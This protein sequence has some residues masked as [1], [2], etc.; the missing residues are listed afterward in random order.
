MCAVL[1]SVA[2][3]VYASGNNDY[4]QY[5]QKGR[6][7]FGNA[8]YAQALA[9]Y[10]EAEQI[11]P[12]SKEA[13]LNQALIYKTTRQYSRAV[14]CYKKLL[15]IQPDQMVHLN[16]G[17][18]YYLNAMP[19]EAI[20][21]LNTALKMGLDEARAYFWLGKCFEDTGQT[22]NALWAHAKAVQSDDA[23]ACAHL[24]L[25]KAYEQKKMWAAAIKEFV[26]VKELDPS[27]VE[28]Y[29]SLAMAYF[30]QDNYENALVAFR[31]VQAI[32][33]D[34]EQ[35]K[36][37][38]D[39]IYRKAGEALKKNLAQRQTKRLDES[40]A[41]KVSPKRA[42]GALVL[43]IH[44]GDSKGFCFKC[45]AD[46]NIEG[47]GGK[48]LF[49][50]EKGCLYS[51][52]IKR[53]NII[54]RAGDKR[55]IEFSQTIYLRQ[56]DAAATILIFNLES[57]TGEYWASKT[58]RLYR[59]E[60][61]L[62]VVPEDKIRIINKVNMEEYLYGVLPSEMDSKW[63]EEA[64]KAQAV[65]ARSEAYAKLGRHKNDGFDFCS[66]VHC[67]VYNGARVE[68]TA[69]NEAVDVTQGEVVA[70]KGIPIDAVY[71]NS[72]GG[73]TQG[74]VF[75]K[76]EPIPYLKAKQDAV[77]ATG[78]F[79]PLSPLEQEDWLWYADIPVFC[80]NEAFSR[81]SNFRWMR[82]YSKLSLEQ[83][84]NKKIDIGRL[85]SIDITERNISGHV[86]R[87]R[88][89]GSKGRFNV[90]KELV[91]RQMLGNLRSSM[92]NIDVKL[93]H[94]GVAQEFIFYGGG[95]G[96]AVGMCQV[97]A[98]TMAQAGYKYDAILKFYYTDVEIKKLY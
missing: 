94:K 89:I 32:D 12:G 47:S 76:R 84:I 62:S 26:K 37:Y 31:K 8:D 57:G 33:P 50:G 70:Y 19:R 68:T 45:A 54:L 52:D 98:A 82:V 21:S 35:V 46:F 20:E 29:W 43:R 83:L 44:I 86:Y 41:K 64:L 79:F 61:E 28:I 59:G 22:D 72:C 95:W 66:G 55:I 60:L 16:M 30:Y 25:G 40:S 81:R 23:F 80:N 5:L 42:D 14:A 27:I 87:I 97:G 56:K 90:E 58:D 63:P 69:T 65:A 93:D 53:G 3:F 1:L 7:A 15:K 34:N 88:I 18:L 49:Q 38:I 10:K 9:A 13:I 74:N 77:G 36:T 11:D 48:V 78:F 39:S 85:I 2:G 91:V 6:T 4:A 71:S 92:F 67:Q 96:H 75:S 17:E 24:S 73:H 51:L